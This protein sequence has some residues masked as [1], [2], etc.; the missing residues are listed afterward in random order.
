MW[1]K[2]SGFKRAAGRPLFVCAGSAPLPVE[3]RYPSPFAGI[4]RTS[5]ACGEGSCA[6][7]VRQSSS[8]LAR[9]A[10]FRKEPFGYSFPKAPFLKGGGEAERRQWRM[11]RDGS[12]VSKEAQGSRSCDNAARPL[13][14]VGNHHEPAVGLQYQCNHCELWATYAASTKDCPSF[15]NFSVA[16]ARKRPPCRRP[17][18][19]QGFFPTE[20]VNY[21]RTFLTVTAAAATSA[22]AII[23]KPTTEALSPVCGGLA[24]GSS[25][26]SS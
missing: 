1:T 10:P 9:T 17:S 22:I 8:P 4:R 2:R 16:L 19:V 7:G 25:V 14:T 18:F 6:S 15:R 3:C 20:K 12:P 23:T 24:D 5:V 21:A 13:R 26:T 11:Q